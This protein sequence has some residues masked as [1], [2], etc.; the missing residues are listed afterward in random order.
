[1]YQNS[2][3]LGRQTLHVE[4][5][6]PAAC[7]ILSCTINGL[8]GVLLLMSSGWMHQAIVGGTLRCTQDL[9]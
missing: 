3:G 1:M 2:T 9:A 6:P 4:P 5:M 8:V 7:D